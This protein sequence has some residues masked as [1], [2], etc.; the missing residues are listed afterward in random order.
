MNDGPKLSGSVSDMSGMDCARI[1]GLDRI[2][3][4]LIISHNPSKIGLGVEK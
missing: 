4:L 1:I 2:G 3:F